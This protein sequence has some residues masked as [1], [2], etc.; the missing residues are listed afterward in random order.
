MSLKQWLNNGFKPLLNPEDKNQLQEILN[1]KYSV[2]LN[3]ESFCI[4]I[5]VRGTE[6]CVVTVLEKKDGSWAYPVECATLNTQE[7]KQTPLQLS[8]ILLDYLDAYWE[9]FLTE[10]RDVFVPIDWF[11]RESEG[12]SLYIRGFVRNLTLES[13]AESLLAEFG[14]GDNGLQPI[15]SEM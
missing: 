3:E 13:Q 5:G 14:R 10:D 11:E 9:E 15:S 8:M 6:V 12:I 2:F 7:T 4:E 1:R